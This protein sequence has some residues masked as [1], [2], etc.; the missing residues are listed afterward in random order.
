MTLLKIYELEAEFSNEFKNFL[1]EVKP[2]IDT[3]DQASFDAR[4]A[5]MMIIGTFVEA[6]REHKQRSPEFR[7]FRQLLT[8]QGWNQDVIDSNSKAFKLHKELKENVNQEFQDLADQAS[9]T[10]LAELQKHNGTSTVIHE[11]AMHLKRTK[12]VPTKEQI[13]GRIAG[14]HDERFQTRFENRSRPALATS[15]EETP[16]MPKKIQESRLTSEHIRL[17]IRSEYELEHA[18][19]LIASESLPYITDL[20]EAIAWWRFS[21][22]RDLLLTVVKQKLFVSGTDGR[23]TEQLRD[24]LVEHSETP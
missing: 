18:E 8:A 7:R 6:A 14:Y 13:R 24:L 2:W 15:K 23:F 5:R 1:T 11:A 9:V 3:Y 22:R 12:K 21:V 19:H 16:S 10:V 20:E 4:K 17:G